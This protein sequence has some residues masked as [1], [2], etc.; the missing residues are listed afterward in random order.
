MVLVQKKK[1][2][3]AEFYTYIFVTLFF[4]ICKLKEAECGSRASGYYLG[5]H[6]LVLAIT[7]YSTLTC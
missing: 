5:Q 3:L 4:G 1:K 7:G 2:A 6:P